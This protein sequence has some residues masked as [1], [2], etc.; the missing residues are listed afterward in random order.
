MHERIFFQLM[1]TGNDF[2]FFNIKKSITCTSGGTK[3]SRRAFSSSL[4][5]LCYSLIR[6]PIFPAAN[7]YLPYLNLLIAFHKDT[8]YAHFQVRNCILGYH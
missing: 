4:S 2:M 8:Y 6:K 3:G 1:K 7:S 5:S